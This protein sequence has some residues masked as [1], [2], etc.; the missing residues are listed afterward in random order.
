[1]S[2]QFKFK[3]KNLRKVYEIPSAVCKELLTLANEA[4]VNCFPEPK[5]GYAAA[6]LT[7]EGNIY[8]GASYKSDTHTLTM[9]GE[10]VALAHAAIHGETK[11]IAIT[12]PNCHCC[13]QLIWESALRSG[14]D[15]IIII[16][17]KGKIKKVPIS[18]LM[19]YPWPEKLGN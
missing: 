15:V 8:Q 5:D 9:H 3:R 16:Q 4:L 13:K 1:M 10:A 12:G 11:I 14:I 6:V 7:E 18:T 19:P 2:K 17:E